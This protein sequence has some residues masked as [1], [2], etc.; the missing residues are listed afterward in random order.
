M[1]ATVASD[2][3]L[4]ADLWVGFIGACTFGFI[5]FLRTVRR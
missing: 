2:S 3:G 1:T 5:A 4:W